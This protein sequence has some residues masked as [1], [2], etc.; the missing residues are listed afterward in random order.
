MIQFKRE[1]TGDKD[2]VIHN[3]DGS[4]YGNLYLQKNYKIESE[5]IREFFP[6]ENVVAQTLE[7]YQELLGVSFSK[8]EHA[9]TWH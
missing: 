7:I 8:L 9:S 6:M 3:W 5:K 4:F 1:L 2:A